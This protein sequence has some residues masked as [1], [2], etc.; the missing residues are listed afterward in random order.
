MRILNS[1]YGDSSGG[2][3]SA[4]LK[5]GE[6]LAHAGHQLTLLIAPA[7]LNKVPDYAGR[8]ID[9]VS[10]KNSG[11]YD[12]IASWKAAR[13]IRDRKIDAII[14]HSG[15]AIHMLK[16]AAPSTVPVIA[17][18]H[19]HNIK[20]T[21]KADAFF[22]ITPYMKHIVDAA[23][24][25]N[26]PSFV[27]SNAVS[28][29]P[30]EVLIASLAERPFT[31]GFIGRLALN[32][33]LPTLIDAAAVL[34][35]QGVEFRLL[36]AGEGEERPMLERKVDELA[37]HD[38]V[39][40]AGWVGPAQKADFFQD[41]DV[42]C[43]PSEW[44]T[45]PLTVLETFAW[46]KALVATDIPGPSSCYEHE[47]TALVVP[48]KDPVAMAAALLRL[49]ENPE[50]RVRLAA[51]GRRQAMAEHADAEVG[52]LLELRLKVLVELFS[53]RES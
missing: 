53:C 50:L 42:I 44:D 3:W 23:T 30:D 28:I 51:N 37:L 39:V 12:L 11:H 9:V 40:F 1:V 48:P 41:C 20:R 16:R 5:T 15:R 32:K 19:S 31:I 45:Q 25:G 52:G 18:N 4:T 46:G 22:C 38:K 14:A 7:D 33:D 43:S 6:L 21:L 47:R 36:L 10:L 49:K 35:R 29:P 2:R 34:A 27:I 26:K 13:L 8:K 24:G 17:F